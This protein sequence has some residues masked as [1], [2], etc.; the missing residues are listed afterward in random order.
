MAL[1]RHIATVGA[2]TMLSRLLGFARDMMIAAAFGAGALTDAFFIA[3]Q[4]PNLAR[5]LM[6]EGALNAGFVPLYLRARDEG[7]PQAAALFAGRVIG[8]SALAFGFATLAMAVAMPLVVIVLAPGFGW[9]DPRLDQAVAFARLMLPYVLFAGPLAAL[10]G[11]L[12]AQHRFG[13]TALATIA[14]NLVLVLAL[15]GLLTA[16]RHGAVL[17]GHGLAAAVG[18]AGLAQLVLVGAVV[19]RSERVPP[20]LSLG[21]EM[22]RFLALAIP[23]LVAGGIPQLLLIAASMVA[24]VT[25]S[26]ISWLYY[27][28]RLVE[29]PLGVV[30]IAI[31][32]V[33]V[34]AFTRAV[35]ENDGDALIATESRGLEL[36]FGL[37]LPAAVALVVLATPIVGVLFERGAFTAADTSATA[38]VLAALALGLPGHVLTKAFSPAFFA[39]EDTQTPMRAALI[40][41]AV[42]VAGSLLLDRLLGPLGIALAT[43]LA[44][45]VSAGLL[46]RAIQRGIGF[47]L[48]TE[49][50]RRLPRIVLAAAGMGIVLGAALLPIDLGRAS[51][52][53][54]VLALGGLVALGLA[55]YLALLQALGVVKV[56]T[57]L[58]ALRRS[59]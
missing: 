42:A 13:A 51:T 22:R 43:A 25:P 48:D 15:A 18:A 50:R 4:L 11:V 24:S 17:T 40:G 45:W 37:A 31:G 39:R 1:V 46:A 57:L 52:L 5:R 7:G 14:F 3:F 19:W 36:S 21:P 28:N 9:S 10:M 16:Q 56:R 20:A 29:L 8:T 26:A 54:R 47:A 58:R 55:S 49:A 59:L 34:P 30:S 2:A 38:A 33:L 53:L 6:A 32:T 12:N 23:G 41:L 44:G 35:R 27:A